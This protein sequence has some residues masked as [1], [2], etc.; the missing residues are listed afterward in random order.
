MQIEDLLKNKKV[1]MIPVYSTRSY[2][3]GK[4]DLAADGNVTKFV[5]KIIASENCDIDILY[6]DNSINLEFAKGVLERAGKTANW[7]PF[8]YGINAHQ[9]RNMG[10]SFFNE[11]KR[12]YE[13]GIKYDIIL[14]E[15]DTLAHICFE[16]YFDFCNDGNLM[17][18]AGSWN[19]DGTRWDEQGHEKI[20]TDIAS[21]FLTPCLLQGQPDLYN[22]YAFYD[23]CKYMPE[24][25][26]K[27]VIFFPFRLSDKSY[28]VD[29]F[30]DV[31]N[32]LSK[33]YDNFVVLYTDPNDSHVFDEYDGDIFIKVPRNKFVYLAIL[34]GR[35]IIPF[36]DKPHE[37]YH[38][39]IYE[40]LYYS[41]RI[42]TFENV[43]CKGN[44]NVSF[45]NGFD[46]LYSALEREIK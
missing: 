6:P 2:D 3:T 32:R 4:Y 36:L 10:T 14:T 41:C 12:R 34:K 9:T 37:N 26:D 28:H 7:I 30:V 38:T 17:Y 8:W 35:P 22:G 5:M 45:I 31:I 44:K 15:V 42:I 39:N 13:S 29:E 23:N 33:T 27:H 40:F 20:N 1:L 43:L 25:F 19:C 46:D 11:I 24:Y 21:K 16:N 18:W